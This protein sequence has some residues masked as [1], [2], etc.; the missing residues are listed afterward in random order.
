MRTYRVE[1]L[2]PRDGSCI[3]VDYVK[4]DLFVV[5]DDNATVTFFVENSNSSMTPVAMFPFKYVLSIV[6]EEGD[7]E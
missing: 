3:N 7:S 1:C 5:S 6:T 4:A 2:D